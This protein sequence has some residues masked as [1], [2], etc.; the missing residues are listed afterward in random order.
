MPDIVSFLALKARVATR[1]VDGRPEDSHRCS[2]GF[3]HRP[4]VPNKS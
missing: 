2:V 4:F 1:V 3:A